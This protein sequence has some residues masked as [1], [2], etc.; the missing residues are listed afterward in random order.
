MKDF[1]ESTPSAM[2]SKLF[3][4]YLGYKLHSTGVP[5]MANESDQEP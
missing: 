3:L 1:D 2:G 5:V 4:C